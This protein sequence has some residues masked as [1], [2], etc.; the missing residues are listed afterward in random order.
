MLFI[1]F[2]ALDCDSEIQCWRGRKFIGLTQR[3]LVTATE[4]LTVMESV[5]FADHGPHERKGIIPRAPRG[6][7]DLPKAEIAPEVLGAEFTR[8]GHEP[9]YRLLRAKFLHYRPITKALQHRR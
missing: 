8:E 6:H 2:I 4:V 9:P 1:A 5:V 7:E 3:D